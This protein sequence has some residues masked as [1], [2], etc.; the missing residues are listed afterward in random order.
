MPP[1]QPQT[2]A[3]EGILSSE[4]ELLITICIIF[5]QFIQK[6]KRSPVT[7]VLERQSYQFDSAVLKPIYGVHNE[8]RK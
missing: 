1:C 6:I 4:G 5:N 8:F 2:S 7:V 3:I